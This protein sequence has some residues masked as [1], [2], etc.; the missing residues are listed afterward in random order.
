MSGRIHIGI[1]GWSYPDWQGVVYPAGKVDQ[2][3]HVARYFDTIELNTTFYQPP[4]ERNVVSWLKRV[5][6]LPDFRF[7]TKL[8]KRFTHD[9]EPVGSGELTA[10]L[11]PLKAIAAEGRLGALLL[12]FPYSFKNTLEGREKLGR[13]LEIFSAFPLVVEIRHDSFNTQEFFKY[14]HSLNVG[15]CNIDQPLI[16]RSIGP[17]DM[18]TSSVGYVRMHGRNY[19]QWFNEEADAT[20]RY[21]YLYS[22]QELQEWAQRIE[23]MARRSA[24]I[25]VIMNNHF[26]GQAPANALQ[27]KSLLARSAVDVP[28]TLVTAFPFLREITR[29]A[30]GQGDLF[31]GD[32]SLL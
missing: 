22:S 5:A 25:Y 28:S 4:P 30:P 3:A 7:T 32:P 10:A 13:L 21:D 17:T 6:Q 2:L 16:S 11:L 15:F 24:T 14:L 8:W 29:R 23:D 1:A 31:E 9:P 27:L 20:T 12:Q 26:H 18:T 19:H